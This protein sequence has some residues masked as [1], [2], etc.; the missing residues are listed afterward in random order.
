MVYK[1]LGFIFESAECGRVDDPVTVTL[2][3]RAVI[4]IL[5]LVASPFGESAACSVTG[6]VGPLY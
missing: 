4:A 6:K 1:H 2:E 3:C 5:F